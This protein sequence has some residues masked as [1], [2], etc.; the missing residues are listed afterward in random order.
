MAKSFRARFGGKAEIQWENNDLHP[1]IKK[2]IAEH[3][4]KE[5]ELRSFGV[6]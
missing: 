4:L 1:I 5:G 2:C 6:N 3:T